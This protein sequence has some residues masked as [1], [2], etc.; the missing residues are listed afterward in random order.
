MGQYTWTFAN[1]KRKKLEY[2]G[3]GYIALP[4]GKFIEEKHYD[5]YGMFGEFDVYEVVVDLNKDYLDTIY[6]KLEQMHPNGFWGDDTKEVAILY[7]ESKY[8][9]IEE[10]VKA[11]KIDEEWKRL[12]GITI[13]CDAVHNQ[14]LPY[15]L[16]IVSSNRVK[17]ENLLPSVYA[18]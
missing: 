13:S 14:I 1:L 18:T 10:Y 4:Y 8:K 5:G 11:G 9:L 15:P 6:W 17:Y 12:I 7:K 16:K 3:K 2:G